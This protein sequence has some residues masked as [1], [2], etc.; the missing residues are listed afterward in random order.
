MTLVN[1]QGDLLA[2]LQQLASSDTLKSLVTAMVTAGLAD[3][4]TGLAGLDLDLEGAS[5]FDQVVQD[6]QRNLVRA[7]V[8]AGVTTAI[9]GGELDDALV[10]ALR[11]AAADTLGQV[12]AEEIGAAYG[13]AIEDGRSP[14][15]YIAHK[16]AHAALGCATGA[17]GSDDC[18][19]G[20]AGG[21]AGA[22]V[23]EAYKEMTLGDELQ[24][25][26]ESGEDDPEV[27]QAKFA[28]WRQR[29]VDLSKLSA[30]L[31]AAAA[32]GDMDV[33]IGTGGNAA[34]NN[35]LPLIL[36]VAKIGLAAYT[37]YEIAKTGKKAYQL[38]ERIRGDEEIPAEELKQLA[39]ELGIELVAG[40]TIS[41][42]NV[43]KAAGSLLRKARMHN[44]ADEVEHRAAQLQRNQNAPN[45]R[46]AWG[47]T[48]TLDDHFD[49]HGADFGARNADD[50]A[51]Q[52]SNALRT[53][54]AERWPTKIDSDGVI[55]VYDPKTNTFGAY[56][57][58]GTT[59]TFFKPKR[60][61]AYWDDRRGSPPIEIGQ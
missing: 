35:V 53:S 36:V 24:S 48:D 45:G 50:Y 54:Q 55:R 34:E 11:M 40:V 57:P 42:L 25:L 46:A 41:K 14:G 39:T 58:D 4:V 33:A 3:K 49:R 13:E 15:E 61:S 32:G 21:V 59:R 38:Y 37:A 26:M 16:V 60:G 19:S 56:N 20:A 7:T 8:R 51:Q 31:L 18:G 22:V 27:L 23:S 47:R 6:L 5:R 12:V 9:Q 17:I 43:L 1:H 2:T 44:K 52:A 28:E 29:G 30:G 10:S